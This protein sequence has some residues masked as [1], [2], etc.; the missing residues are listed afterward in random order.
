MFKKMFTG[1]KIPNLIRWIFVVYIIFFFSACGHTIKKNSASANGI[2]KIPIGPDQV[3][4]LSGYAGG[5]GGNPLQ[6]V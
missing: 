5:G 2:Q 4:D 6:F 1:L 3:Y